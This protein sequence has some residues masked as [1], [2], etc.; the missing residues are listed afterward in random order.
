MWC[1]VS[2]NSRCRSETCCTWLAENKRRKNS[3]S[4]H[5]HTTLSGCIFATEARIDNWKNLLSSNIPSTWPHNMNFDPLAAEIGL[6]V[7]GTSANFNKFCLGSVTAQHSSTGYQP[8]FKAL[9]IGPPIFSRAAITLGISRHSTLCCVAVQVFWL[10]NVCF[11]VR[12]SFSIPSRDW[13][14]NVSEMTFTYFVEWDIK[15]RPI[16]GTLVR[17]NVQTH[18]GHTYPKI[19]ILNTWRMTIEGEGSLTQVYLKKLLNGGD[20]NSFGTN[21]C[22]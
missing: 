18:T 11:C 22:H 5:H 21:S 8:N 20:S 16:Y 9:N 6:V 7:W 14:G 15:P 4:G 12:F 1:G 19:F 3:P 13:L 2:V 17:S 10:V